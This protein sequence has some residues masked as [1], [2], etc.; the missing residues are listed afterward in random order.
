M[1]DTTLRVASVCCWFP[2]MWAWRAAWFG[3]MPRVHSL[4]AVSWSSTTDAS[5]LGCGLRVIAHRVGWR[6]ATSW[7]VQPGQMVGR[8]QSSV[9]SCLRSVR[10]TDCCLAN[11]GRTS[12]RGP[13][14]DA[15]L[16][17]RLPLSTMD[18]VLE[19]P[20]VGPLDRPQR[21]V[22]RV[23]ERDE[24]CAEPVW[25]EPEHRPRQLL[26][27]H[28]GMPAADPQ[29]G[30]LDHDAHGRLAEVVPQHLALVVVGRDRADYGDRGR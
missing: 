28:D 7:I 2:S 20:P 24:A 30:R 8:A 15:S 4:Q 3:E 9:S 29:V 17:A 14:Q 27:G 6:A 18:D 19:G 23:A 13:S 10:T 26:I 21:P 22:G 25:R 1:I 5:A 12:M 11:S 16:I